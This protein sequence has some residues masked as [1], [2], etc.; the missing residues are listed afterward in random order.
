MTDTLRISVRQWGQSR[1][2][3]NHVYFFLRSFRNTK[4]ACSYNTDKASYISNNKDN[5]CGPECESRKL[6][7][8][9]LMRR[10]VCLF[11]SH[12]WQYRYSSDILRSF[13][14]PRRFSFLPRA[15]RGCNEPRYLL[16]SDDILGARL[17]L[18]VACLTSKRES[19]LSNRIADTCLWCDLKFR[20]SVEKELEVDSR[21]PHQKWISF[22]LGPE[23]DGLKVTSPSFQATW[24][25]NYLW[26]L[27]DTILH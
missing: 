24:R 2:I 27:V 19:F 4:T 5:S 22:F 21:K 17:T 3:E 23:K 6:P 18:H 15:I 25:F 9:L 10:D 12:N 13:A 20:A 14:L 7:T 16:F 26:R 11:A 1:A 8:G